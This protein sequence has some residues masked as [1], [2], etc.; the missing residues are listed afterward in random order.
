ME[1]PVFYTPGPENG[2]LCIK[3]VTF[4]IQ[5]DVRGKGTDEQFTAFSSQSQTLYNLAASADISCWQEAPKTAEEYLSGLSIPHTYYQKTEP[6]KPGAFKN[7]GIATIINTNRFYIS[8]IKHV[9]FADA[10]NEPKSKS[11]NSGHF[12][13]QVDL[14]DM[15]TNIH[16][17]LFNTHIRGDPGTPGV[18]EKEI[19][20]LIRDFGDV[21]DDVD[22]VI[23]CGDFNL[24]PDHR[25]MLKL[26]NEGK[27]NVDGAVENTSSFGKLDYVLVKGA[28]IIRVNVLREYMTRGVSDHTPLSVV[29]SYNPARYRY[30]LGRKI[31]TINTVQQVDNSLNSKTHPKPPPKLSPRSLFPKQLYA[32]NEAHAFDISPVDHD[33]GRPANVRPRLFWNRQISGSDY[34][35]M[36][37][38]KG[39]TPEEGI[40]PSLLNQPFENQPQQ[41]YQQ[42]QSYNPQSVGTAYQTYGSYQPQ[43]NYYQQQQ[44]IYSQ[45]L[46]PNFMAPKQIQQQRASLPN[47]F[48]RTSFK[49]SVLERFNNKL[50]RSNM[51][52][53]QQMKAS[54]YASDAIDHSDKQVQTDPRKF[55]GR[56]MEI[57]KNSFASHVSR[58]TEYDPETLVGI[59]EWF[60]QS[61]KS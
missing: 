56:F 60:E 27:F 12:Y 61:F 41:N 23:G 14:I 32:I 39:Q 38:S 33:C 16:I 34:I 45:P 6:H 54:R 4:N 36:L 8:K 11:N 50:S 3:I 7:D 13:T 9:V 21:K 59:S 42:A 49:F 40:D 20:Q 37:I 51:T 10:T 35:Q 55:K 5:T 48:P 57:A 18:T 46:I 47:K 43:T 30:N 15:A 17:R 53:N 19:N 22:V 29:I 25:L 52:Y 26:V 24:K 1:S 31:P 2:N 28:D 58:D 44:P